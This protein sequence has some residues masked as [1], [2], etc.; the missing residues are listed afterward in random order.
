[1]FTNQYNFHMLRN[2]LANLVK[3]INKSK[4]ALDKYGSLEVLVGTQ[5]WDKGTAELTHLTE[6][7]P[8]GVYDYRA[9]DTSGP[10]SY[11]FLKPFFHPNMKLPCINSENW[12]IL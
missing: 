2:N 7:G 12:L 8:R 1:M 3:G 11:V 5:L 9:I 4:H 10:Y 6:S